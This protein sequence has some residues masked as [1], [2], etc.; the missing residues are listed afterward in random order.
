MDKEKVLNLAKLARIE[1]SDE[2]AGALVRE[3][4]SILKYVGEIKEVAEKVPG[5]FSSVRNIMREDTE[6]HESGIYT[7]ELL[8]AAPQREGDYVRVK[9][10]L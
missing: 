1:V 9:K 4:D 8:N 10:I 6:P 5:T 2:E 3:F 7:E